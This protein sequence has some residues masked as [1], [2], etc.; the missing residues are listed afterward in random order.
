[1]EVWR[2]CTQ[3]HEMTAFSGDDGLYAPGRWHPQGSPIIY[4]ASSLSLATL[5]LLMPLE[6]QTIPLVAIRAF[7]PDDIAIETVNVL[8]LPANWQDIAAYPQLQAIGK[9]WLSEN[10]TPILKV[11]SAI[12]P[13]EFIY[14][15]NPRHLDLK[16]ELEPSLKF[17][18]AERKWTEIKTEMEMFRQSLQRVF[19]LSD[20]DVFKQ[21][22]QNIFTISDL[23]IFRQSLRRILDTLKDS[24]LYS[25]N[26]SFDQYLLKYQA[27]MG[28]DTE[29]MVLKIKLKLN[30]E[31][32][33]IC[34]KLITNVE[35]LY[36]KVARI[37][38]PAS[39]E[40]AIQLL[41]EFINDF[42]KSYNELIDD[43]KDSLH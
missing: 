36:P 43:L 21:S 26:Q 16:I 10:K 6:S 14:L 42:A 12:V 8:S 31:S 3:K 24:Q 37:T 2:I 35:K 5:E 29:Q 19:T 32:D 38:N 22:L 11:P 28:A 39:K 30:R 13:A 7:I 41:E 15:L 33:L 20:L 18:F 25:F 23:E 40:E 34:D 17:T 1:M 9:K 4:T 27:E